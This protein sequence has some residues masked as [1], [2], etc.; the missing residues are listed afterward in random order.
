MKKA[1]VLSYP[2]S[3]QQRLWSDW[4]DA[5]ADLSLRL[6]HSHFV[7]F[8]WGGS[9][10]NSFLFY[11]QRVS[12]FVSVLTLTTISVERYLAICR[13]LTYRRTKF[14]TRI[15][16]A[17]I[18]CVAMVTP[19]QE[20]FT[21]DLRHDEHV[22]ESLRPLLS[23]CGPVNEKVE[24]EFTLFL[25]VAFYLLPLCVMTFTYASIARCLWTSTS[26]DSA[27]SESKLACT[28]TILISQTSKSI[29]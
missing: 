15:A 2:L 4:A 29:R 7:V 23:S 21:I 8:S 12:V 26:D 17:V 14:K 5:Q 27:V 3:A 25:I 22:R 20:F 24:L 18:W 1:W 19:I 10:I 16:L 28:D 6:A 11:F 9:Y 13:P